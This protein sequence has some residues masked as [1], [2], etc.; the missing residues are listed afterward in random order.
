MCVG[1]CVSTEGPDRVTLSSESNVWLEGVETELRC[2]IENAAPGRNLSV[3]W[4]RT[5]P[6]LNI[7]TRFNHTTFPDLE[8]EWKNVTKT[9]SQTVTPRQEDDG[10]QYQCA[11]VLNLDHYQITSPSQPITITVHCE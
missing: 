9:A 2:V 7:S 6:K 4:S 1:V 11:A 3:D 8:K 10:A 5:D